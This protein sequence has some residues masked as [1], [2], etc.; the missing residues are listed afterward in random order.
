LLSDPR[1]LPDDVS[2]LEEEMNKL[3]SRWKQVLEKELPARRKQRQVAEFLAEHGPEIT[4]ALE[5]LEVDDDPDL[6]LEKTHYI[7]LREADAILGRLHDLHALALREMEN[8]NKLAAAKVSALADLVKDQEELKRRAASA[9]QQIEAI[10]TAVAVRSDPKYGRGFTFDPKD[11]KIPRVQDVEPTTA[12]DETAAPDKPTSDEA[13]LTIEEAEPGSESDKLDVGAE[14][15]APEPVRGDIATPD[16]ES[17]GTEQDKDEKGEEQPAAPADDSQVTAVIVEPEVVPEP[18]DAQ[19]GQQASIEEVTVANQDLIVDYREGRI[20]SIL[21]ALGKGRFSEAFWLATEEERH[22]GETAVPSWIPLMGLLVTSRAWTSPDGEDL[23]RAIRTR[24]SNP[25]EGLGDLFRSTL[26]PDER[27]LLTGSLAVRPALL[28]PDLGHLGWIQETIQA[29]SGASNELLQFF[30]RIEEFLLK[31]QMFNRGLLKQYMET[32]AWKEELGEQRDLLQQ[33]LR[34][35]SQA[36]TAYRGA[37]AVLH[38]VCGEEAIPGSLVRMIVG[39]ESVKAEVV[40]R[41]EELLREQLSN[42]RSIEEFIQ[43]TNEKLFGHRRARVREITGVALEQ[44]I[45]A[46][47]ELRE[48]LEDW[49]QLAKFATEEREQ[50]DWRVQQALAFRADIVPLWE[51]LRP[52]HAVDEMGPEPGKV[53]RSV[54]TRLIDVVVQDDLHLQA[55]TD[56]DWRERLRRPALVLDDPPLTPRGNLVM[57]P[58]LPDGESLYDRLT[59]PRPYEEAFHRHLK[60]EDFLA[61]QAVVQV[62]EES[63]A[64]VADFRD[65]VERR[66]AHAVEDIKYQAERMQ[67]RMVRATMEH[68]LSEGR[69]AEF[70]GQLLTL[71]KQAEEATRLAPLRDQLEA[72]DK[73]LETL[74]TSRYASLKEQ[75]ENEEEAWANESD[76]EEKR[77]ALTY[78]DQARMALQEHDL[79]RADEYLTLVETGDDFLA[80]TSSPSPPDYLREFEAAIPELRDYLLQNKRKWTAVARGLVSEIGRGRSVA[81]LDMRDVPGARYREAR[82]GLEAYIDLKRHKPSTAMEVRQAVKRLFEYIGFQQV[83]VD[84]RTRGRSSA[85]FQVRMSGESPVADFGSLRNGLYDVVVMWYRPGPDTIGQILESYNLGDRYPIILFLGLLSDAQRL[86]WAEFCHKNNFTALL[87]DEL[88]LFFLASQRENRIAAAVSCAIAWGYADPY[89]SSGMIPPE[90]FK[91]RERELRSLGDPAGKVIIY[92]GRQF[93]K[94]VMLRMLERRLHDPEN[95]SYVRYEDIKHVGEQHDVYQIWAR[96][97]DWLVELDLLGANAG[98]N[99]ERVVKNARRAFERDP[100]LRL[101]L[102]LDEADR[103]I[104]QDARRDFETLTMLRQIMEETN[105]RFKIILSGLHSVQRYSDVANHPFAQYG[106]P[107][108]I[109]PLRP[110]AAA[111]LIME[112]LYTMGFRFD[113]Q[114]AEGPYPKAVLRILSYTNYHPALIQN[115]CSELIRLVRSRDQKPPYTIKLKDVEAVYR[116]PEVRQFMRER[117]EWTVALNARYE[118]LVY[119]MIY[120]QLDNE[121]GYRRD[122]A[123]SEILDIVLNYWREGFVDV[124][125]NEMKSLLVELEGLGVLIRKDNGRYRLRN[126]NVVRAL[127]SAREI[128]NRL[129]EFESK[130]AP[131]RFDPSRQMVVLNGKPELRAPLT[132]QQAGKLVRQERGICLLFGSTGLGIGHVKETFETLL[133]Q[134]A[135]R[136]IRAEVKVRLVP[137]DCVT[138]RQLEACLA[139]FQRE[140]NHFVLLDASQLALAA[141]DLDTGLRELQQLVHALR[142]RSRWIRVVVVVDESYVCEWMK[143]DRDTREFFESQADTVVIQKWDR[144]MLQDFLNKLELLSTGDVVRTVLDHTGGWP[145]LMR[146]FGELLLEQSEAGS[147]PR[148]QSGEIC[149]RVKSAGEARG[150]L[151]DLGLKDIPNATTILRAITLLAP[152]LEEVPVAVEAVTDREQKEGDLR[153]STRALER[154]GLI[155]EDVDGLPHVESLALQL[156]EVIEWD[157]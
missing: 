122:F 36:G 33:W 48:L 68:I 35:H 64:E 10:R 141:G 127:G 143:L 26:N 47:Q 62:M 14:A 75:I 5:R 139:Q 106:T 39:A 56:P 120:E 100:S 74:R 136:G 77:Q 95:N 79:P 150:F 98:T 154:L 92:G 124:S 140:S 102:L 11:Y 145:Q 147:N 53:V 25:Q 129:Q 115:F 21:Q 4:K 24:F 93:G 157:V 119:S 90:I 86:E 45:R 84:A 46:L 103:F 73:Q 58:T 28:R 17:E 130:P 55:Q 101:L 135:T 110:R 97:R 51:E 142:P 23:L 1:S 50:L 87:M 3:M 156:L 149:E 72:I 83:T 125:L 78:L 27:L 66:Q 71:E 59:Q 37:T 123:A 38:Y 70:E 9:L 32:Y 13:E 19:V 155:E 22:T 126:G 44:L 107:V 128:Q 69:R 52:A 99:P 146:E 109:G 43:K 152:T 42:R 63:G 65:E 88:L 12:K 82:Q 105:M 133:E 137:V 49:R 114:E 112:P 131:E 20:A 16:V 76:C 138:T 132:Y 41:V 116:R 151:D 6:E 121:D 80:P 117:F 30:R 2:Q 111:A 40:R 67:D 57:P 31:V 108:V 94:S 153:A 91:G 144:D 96:I 8:R 113:E 61:A 34:Q 148:I 18:E 89:K 7:T 54:A 104:E 134:Q 118:A 29:S 81:G 15:V 85:H 60:R